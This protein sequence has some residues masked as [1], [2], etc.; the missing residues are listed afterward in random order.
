[1]K[2]W[3]KIYV[4]TLR[5]CLLW[6]LV[7]AVSSIFIIDLWLKSI[8]A[9]NS[10]FFVC[11]IFVH[12]LSI[13]YISSLIFYFIVV[14][15]NRQ[16]E[17][18][19]L[20][21]HIGHLFYLII[22]DGKSIFSDMLKKKKSDFDLNDLTEELI[23]NMCSNTNPY[24]NSPILAW[25]GNTY[26]NWLLYLEEKRMRMEKFRNSILVQMPYL[27]AEFVGILNQFS[28]CEFF[29]GIDFM[30]KIYR[31]GKLANKDFNNGIEDSFIN[32]YKLL[33][34][35]ID[36]YNKEFKNYIYGNI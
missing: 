25:T 7:I 21:K 16:K 2:H 17:K 8:P 18:T 3:L 13:S 12:D 15:Y 9:P 36:Y 35:S 33:V 20:Y 6:L 23:K 1:M 28:D 10:F 4:Y 19:I 24:D 11:G 34:K 31:E 32:Y 22:D 27:E 30:V 14:H 29:D 26:L 5:S